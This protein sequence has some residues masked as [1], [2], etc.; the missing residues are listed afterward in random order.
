MKVWLHLPEAITYVESSRDPEQ[1]VSFLAV[2]MVM[3]VYDSNLL[4][5]PS[6]TLFPK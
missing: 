6:S 4:P 3:F 5:T 1:H 2:C